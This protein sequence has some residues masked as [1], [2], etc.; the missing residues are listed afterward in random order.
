[1]SEIG[2]KRPSDDFNR[3]PFFG[4]SLKLKPR[5]AQSLNAALKYLGGSVGQYP[6]PPFQ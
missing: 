6:P 3:G 2:Q 1:M 5:L 4:Q